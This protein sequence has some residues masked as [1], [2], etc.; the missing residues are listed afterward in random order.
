MTE[1]PARACRAVKGP[2]LAFMALAMATAACGGAEPAPAKAPAHVRPDATS[3]EDAASEPRTIEEAEQRIAEAR[4]TLDSRNAV[5]A[6]E[7]SPR[8][9]ADRS[10]G[11]ASA[12]EE[13]EDV[14]RSPCRAL[15]SLRRAVEALCRMTGDTDHRCVDARRTLDESTSRVAACTCERT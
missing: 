13:H 14:C 4:A 12:R 9:Q 8:A 2:T 5:K 15:A 1:H 10:Q 6:T 7:A 11:G 3:E